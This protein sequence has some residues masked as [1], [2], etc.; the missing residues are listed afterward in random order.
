[1]IG[2]DGGLHVRKYSAQE[3]GFDSRARPIPAV[4]YRCSESLEET[5]EKG[6]KEIFSGR[7][8]LFLHIPAMNLISP[9]R[10]IFP[11]LAITE[12]VL[13]LV[14]FIRLSQNQIWNQGLKCK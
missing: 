1:M 10:N 9:F 3:R 4:E 6:M 8:S 5:H 14:A 2:F 13:R 12:L 11:K 7:S